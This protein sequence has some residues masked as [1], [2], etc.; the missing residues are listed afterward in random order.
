MVGEQS[1]GRPVGQPSDATLL[2]AVGELWQ[3]VDPPPVDLVDG[4]L[5]AIAAEDLEFDLLTLVSSDGALAGVRHAAPEER[6]DAGAWMLE[7]EGP[8]VR[9][10]VRLNR[11]ED[12]TRVDGWVV[13]VRELTVQLSTEGHDERIESTVDE[14]GRFEFASAK[15][16]LSLLTFLDT[17]GGTAR[18]R[19]TPPFWI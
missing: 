17:S 19:V 10:Y 7:Y 14:F 8:G 2:T 16:G 3:L 18:P 6:D 13:P 5:A 1:T 12:R 9:I 4:V 15:P 11:I